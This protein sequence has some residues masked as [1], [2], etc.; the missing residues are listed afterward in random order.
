MPAPLIVNA[1]AVPSVKPFRSRDAPEITTVP[2]A[3]V[4]RGVFAAPPAAP[5]LIVPPL[6][7]VRPVYVLAPDRVHVPASTFVTVPAPVPMMLARLLPVAVP[8]SVK[9]RP[10]PVIVPVLEIVISPLLATMLVAL[11]MP[12]SPL[13]AAAVAELLVSAPPLL[14]PVPLSV[15]ALVLVTL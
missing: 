4:P 12:M 8:P 11:P 3:V 9:P 5:N 1:S 6:I 15:R 14:T 7:V 10:E 13:K 2:A